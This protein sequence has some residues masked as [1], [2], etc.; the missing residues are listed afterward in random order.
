MRRKFVIILS[1]LMMLLL[2]ACTSKAVRDVQ[3]KI[4]AIGTVT[5]DSKAQIDEIES[6]YSQLADEEKT[7]VENIAVFEE[8]KKEYDTLNAAK[9]VTDGY[10]YLCGINGKGK[11]LQ[12]AAECFEEADAL[13]NLDGTLLAGWV[14]D[15]EF[16]KDEGQDF[17]KA[18]G[19][20]EKCK[21]DNP[22]ANISLG[23]NYFYG[24]GVE[25]DKTKGKECF[26]E[27]VT[28]I[29]SGNCDVDKYPYVYA[30]TIGCMYKNEDIGYQ[31]Y[32]KSMEW[33]EK[34][35]DAGNADAMNMIGQYYYYGLGVEQDYAKAMECFEKAADAGNTTAMSNIGDLYNAGY[36]VEQDYVKAMEWHEKAADAGEAYSMNA[37][38]WYYKHGYG[39]EQDYAKAMEWYEKAADVGIAYAMNM[40]GLYYH[41]GYGVEQDYAKA[42][43]W[44]KKA[45]DAGNTTAMSNIGVLYAD[46]QGV[47]QDYA[48]AM[49]W[50]EK[51]AD[52]GDTNAMNN[53][54][55][56]YQHG[57]GVERDYAKAMEWY[58][59]GAD[60]GNNSAMNNTGYMYEN[61]LGVERNIE[62]ALEW[63]KKAADLGNEVAIENV[64]K[65]KREYG[66]E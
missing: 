9:L 64:K 5:L 48:K 63:Y 15:W 23:Y 51:A 20:Y 58:K 27:A 39:V 21:N 60:A 37:V 8:A 22:I 45:A 49:E 35:A 18:R 65:I 14:Y 30:Y 28:M 34:A 26:D 53:I 2:T 47:E 43:E 40:I 59:K 50:Y 29:E 36:G 38:G 54:G 56:N 61:G 31:D 32:A 1:V 13:G 3:E 16:K 7:E 10:D 62:I 55:W 4:D 11:D 52:A 41:A 66:L 17:D 25:S 46:G 24:Q 19:Y 44:Y 57:Y 33:Y 12:K 6:L 42:M